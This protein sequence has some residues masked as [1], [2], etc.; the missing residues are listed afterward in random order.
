MR[1]A[2]VVFSL[3]I[4]SNP[5]KQSMLPVAVVDMLVKK[6]SVLFGILHSMFSIISRDIV[7]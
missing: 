7:I 3:N 2:S 4:R 5:P 6:A 1:V